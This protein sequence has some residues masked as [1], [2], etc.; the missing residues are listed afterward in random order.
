ML[1]SKCGRLKSNKGRN[2]TWDSL[3][4][5]ESQCPKCRDKLNNLTDLIAGDENDGVYWAI[6][7]ELY[8]NI[9]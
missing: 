3:R 5:H 8:D 6:H 1:K 2:F 7:N 9:P 4:D